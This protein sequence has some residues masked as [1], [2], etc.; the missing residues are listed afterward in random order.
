MKPFTKITIDDKVSVFQ[1]IALHH[2]ILKTLGELS[3]FKDG[4]RTLGVADAIESQGE[5]LH[6]FFVNI[7][8]DL[9]AGECK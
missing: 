3:Q 6:D 8:S 7:K 2:V 4:L 1:S 5:L 9:T